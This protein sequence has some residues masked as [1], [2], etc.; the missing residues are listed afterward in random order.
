MKKYLAFSTALLLMFNI[1]IAKADVQGVDAGITPD[2]ILYPV[3][4]LIDEVKISLTFDE[5]KKAEVTADVAEERLV[6][7]QV[8]AEE[9]KEELVK[10]TVEEYQNKMNDAQEIVQNIVS[11]EQK[12]EEVKKK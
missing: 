6:E 8:M 1:T 7:A 10:T 2:S 12:D 3:D 4:K 5:E 9:G 11:E